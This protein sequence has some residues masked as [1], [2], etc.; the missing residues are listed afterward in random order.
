LNFFY[1]HQALFLGTENQMPIFNLHVHSKDL[2]AFNYERRDRYLSRY[3]NLTSI[4]L[5]THFSFLDFLFHLT[6]IIRRLFRK[7]FKVL[8]SG[9]RGR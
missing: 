2:S 1:R 6:D 8:K 4:K 7:A 5:K 9:L 3:L